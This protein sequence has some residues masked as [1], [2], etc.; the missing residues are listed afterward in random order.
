MEE[1]EQVAA[2]TRARNKQLLALVEQMRQ[3]VMDLKNQVMA[4]QGCEAVQG[5]VSSFKVV[6]SGLKRLMLF[7]VPRSIR[8]L[9]SNQV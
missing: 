9:R 7:N 2:D 3:E 8:Y 5:W 1:L 4:H 6:D